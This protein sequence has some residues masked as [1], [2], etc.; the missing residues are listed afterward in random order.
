VSRSGSPVERTHAGSTLRFN[1]SAQQRGANR[2]RQRMA[3]AAEPL[4]VRAHR[5]R[6]E[7]ERGSQSG[8][9]PVRRPSP[10]GG[11]PAPRHQLRRKRAGIPSGSDGF[12]RRLFTPVESHPGPSATGPSLGEKK[13][14]PKTHLAAAS[15]A[16]IV[17]QQAIHIEL[18]TCAI[19]PSGIVQECRFSAGP[20][21]STRRE[22]SPSPRPGPSPT[23]EPKATRPKVTIQRV[24]DRAG[25]SHG[26]RFA[27]N[28][29]PTRPIQAPA[30]F[31]PRE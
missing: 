3:R 18:G 6:R 11:H 24:K 31:P 9:R 25:S 7:S 26:G 2:R 27:T 28:A 16:A 15:A 19:V 30:T 13:A 29:E 4:L 23:T 5:G 14:R 8:R 12:P 20:N 22:R 17:A 1:G 10:P 21:R